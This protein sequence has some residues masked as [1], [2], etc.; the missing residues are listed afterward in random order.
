MPNG[1]PE[2]CKKISR[3]LPSEASVTTGDF[4]SAVL[5]PHRGAR[6]LGD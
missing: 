3:W 4:V 2:G 1:T 5:A 6:I